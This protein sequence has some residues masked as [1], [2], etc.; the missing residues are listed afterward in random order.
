MANL[1]PNP[2]TYRRL[3]GSLVY[4]TIT[5]PDISYVVNL[6]SQFM[7]SHTYLHLT[8]VKRIIRYLLGKVTCGLYYPKDNQLQLTNYADADWASC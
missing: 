8:A 7:T 3:V 2:H 5:R 1:L 4:L 6:V